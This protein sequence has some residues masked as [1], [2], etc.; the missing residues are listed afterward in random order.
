M[1]KLEEKV[2]DIEDTQRSR[3]VQIVEISEERT[4]NK[5]KNKY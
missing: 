3:N 5:G 1:K 4:H 2:T